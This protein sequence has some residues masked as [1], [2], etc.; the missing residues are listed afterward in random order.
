[1]CEPDDVYYLLATS[2][3]VDERAW[4]GQGTDLGNDVFDCFA[5]KGVEMKNYLD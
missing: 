2:S 1:M 3:A 4:C 5:L